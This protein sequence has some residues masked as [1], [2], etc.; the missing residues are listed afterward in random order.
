MAKQYDEAIADSEVKN[1]DLLAARERLQG[2]MDSL[3]ISQNS[4]NSLRR[5]KK[6]FLALEKE[7]DVLLTENDRLK[8]ENQISSPTDKVEEEAPAQQ[9][10]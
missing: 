7:M 6:K 9:Q 8:V 2:I 10:N 3:K 5:Y 1:Q 4:V